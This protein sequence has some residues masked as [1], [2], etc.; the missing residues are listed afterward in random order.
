MMDLKKVM[1]TRGFKKTEDGY[2]EV[3]EFLVD[4]INSGGIF[5]SD[6]QQT[7]WSSATPNRVQRM[8]EDDRHT[9]SSACIVIDEEEGLSHG[10]TLK[11][12]GRIVGRTIKVTV[13]GAAKIVD[14]VEVIPETNVEH[15]VLENASF[16]SFMRTYKAWVA[17]CKVHHR[18]VKTCPYNRRHEIKFN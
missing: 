10:S 17:K 8:V 14:G 1:K 11:Q 4:E 18:A 3:A 6:E 7:R 15:E 16:T 2:R 12:M 13:H 5:R 9:L